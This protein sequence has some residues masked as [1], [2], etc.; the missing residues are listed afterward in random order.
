MWVVDRHRV[1]EEDSQPE[2]LCV[3][4][5]HCVTDTV[6]EMEGVKDTV[7]VT[8]VAMTDGDPDPE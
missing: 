5:M 6:E 2:M 4:D 3:E 8:P 7:N 1:G